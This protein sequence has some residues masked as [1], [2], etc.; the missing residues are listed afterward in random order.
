M[1]NNVF[2][3]VILNL[4]VDN[5]PSTY[6]ITLSDLIDSLS[7]SE[8]LEKLETAC[9]YYNEYYTSDIPLF[10]WLHHKLVK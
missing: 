9:K 5:S 1:E 10:T 6:K 8:K 4:S 3:K 2:K 7:D